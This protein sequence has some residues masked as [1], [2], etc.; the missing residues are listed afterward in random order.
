[1]VSQL[2]TSWSG[3]RLSAWSAAHRLLK[4]PLGRPKVARRQANGRLLCGTVRS[5]FELVALIFNASRSRASLIGYA[6]VMRVPKC[7]HT[8]TLWSTLS[9]APISIRSPPLPPRRKFNQ[10][11]RIFGFR[12]STFSRR[13]NEQ[14]KVGQSIICVCLASRMLTCALLQKEFRDFERN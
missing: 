3:F 2:E 11:Q 1:M 10:N 12:S 13:Q 5:W 6:P 7:E 9:D 8:H 4:R 14:H